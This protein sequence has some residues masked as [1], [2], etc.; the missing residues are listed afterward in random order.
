MFLIF[1][2]LDPKPINR[3]L[4]QA[5]G[6]ILVEAGALHGYRLDQ[7]LGAAE[8]EASSARDQTHG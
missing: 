5:S 1:N 3:R 8:H 6:N 7:F 4:A 2:P